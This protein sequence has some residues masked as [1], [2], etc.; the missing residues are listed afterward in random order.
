MLT[1]TKEPTVL[2]VTL[3]QNSTSVYLYIRGYRSDD[4]AVLFRHKI[5]DAIVKGSIS[6][7]RALG[8][9]D[10]LTKYLRMRIDEY[11]N[12]D[13]TCLWFSKENHAVCP[14]HKE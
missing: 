4:M 8:Y 12:E 13:C 2:P 3:E 9:M 7:D 14:I 5:D 6:M 11:L 1:W 10:G